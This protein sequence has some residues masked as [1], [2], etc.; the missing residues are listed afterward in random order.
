MRKLFLV[1][2]TLLFL[3]TLTTG[4]PRPK[5]LMETLPPKIQLCINSSHVAGF[6][7]ENFAKNERDIDKSRKRIA[8]ENFPLNEQNKLLGLLVILHL[9][10]SREINPTSIRSQYYFECIN[11]N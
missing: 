5:T 3:S 1:A 9:S 2:S 7:A 11:S 8:G 6:L 10:D 4:Q